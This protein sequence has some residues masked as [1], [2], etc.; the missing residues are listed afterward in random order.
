MNTFKSTLLQ[1]IS[2]AAKSGKR[3]IE[4]YL[5]PI[6]DASF[7]KTEE[8]QLR[9]TANTSSEMKFVE[10]NASVSIH[11]NV[12]LPVGTAIFVVS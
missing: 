6:E 1:T 3:K 5:S 4:V 2:L 12:D 11:R 7:V 9:L 10:H 8:G